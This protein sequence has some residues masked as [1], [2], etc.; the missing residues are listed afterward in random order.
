MRK[1]IIG[2]ITALTLLGAPAA[3]DAAAAA[4]QRT[5]ADNQLI[6]DPPCF[7]NTPSSFNV[8]VN[9]V[10]NN[11]KSTT[12][13]LADGTTVV[14]TT[15][16]LVLSFTNETTGKTIVKNVSGPTTMTTH[17]DGSG[18]FQGTGNNWLG[19][20]PNGQKNTGEPGLV[21]T[22]GQVTVTF[23]SGTA[24]TFSLN[25]HQDNGCAL[26]S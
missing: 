21:F 12:T 15:G 5:A 22:S 2:A 11:E 16:K 1:L 17:P 13:T 4:P 18:V 8:A 25:G 10:T 14:T 6:A 20:G 19:F 23:A 9:T 26:L 7:P 24:Q 3:A